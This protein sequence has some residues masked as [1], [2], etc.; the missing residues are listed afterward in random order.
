[1]FKLVDILIVLLL[2][3][4]MYDFP[5]TIDVRLVVCNYSTIV[6]HK[7]GAGTVIEA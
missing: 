3:F 6:Y 1:M 7:I 5:Q 4:A 2:V